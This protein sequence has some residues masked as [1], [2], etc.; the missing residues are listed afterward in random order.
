MSGAKWWHLQEIGAANVQSQRSSFINSYINCMHWCVHR[1]TMNLQALK[2]TMAISKMHSLHCTLTIH[3]LHKTKQ[4]TIQNRLNLKKMC[5]LGVPE[6]LISLYIPQRIKTLQHSL[7]IAQRPRVNYVR[8]NLKLN[9][10]AVSS[11]I[12]GTRLLNRITTQ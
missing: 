12:K 3:L 6:I 4:I 8:K 11:P 10:T 7:L 5:F 1:C 2:V 9:A